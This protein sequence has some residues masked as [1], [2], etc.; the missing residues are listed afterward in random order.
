MRVIHNDIN[1]DATVKIFCGVPSSKK[2]KN[3]NKNKSTDA[4]ETLEALTVKTTA[5]T[6][7]GWSRLLTCG[8]P[9]T[10]TKGDDDFDYTKSEE[11]GSGSD[12]TKDAKSSKKKKSKDK[13]KRE[14]RNSG[15]MSVFSAGEESRYSHADNWDARS[16]R[17]SATSPSHRGSHSLNTPL[18][19]ESELMNI[20]LTAVQHPST[21]IPSQEVGYAESVGCDG[22]YECIMKPAVVTTTTCCK[23]TI[24]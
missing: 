7:S 15:D 5:A 21:Q 14:R 10:C 13:G 24:M 19:E 12:E 8:G 9:P 4:V 2:K 20:E 11:V 18:D 3:K 23:C 6:S 1:D 22:D 17:S 16:V